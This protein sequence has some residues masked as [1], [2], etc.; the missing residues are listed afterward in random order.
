MLG[1][2]LAQTLG[3]EMP[4]HHPQLQRA[5]ASAQLNA[6]VHQV[7]DA[8]RPFARLQILGRQRKRLAHDVHAT[9]GED[10]QIE[11]REEP[12]VWIDHQRVC[13]VGA[14]ENPFV[15]GDHRG[16]A[17]ICRVD[18]Q[19]HALAF[20]QISTIAGKRIDAGARRRADRGDDRERKSS[21]PARPP[22]SRS[23]ARQARMRKSPSTGIFR[24]ES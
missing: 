10:T 13:V 15:A 19:P 17:G 8:G 14:T 1:E 7:P 18:V 11:R 23:P 22:R 24:S 4:Q 21:A 16:R 9:A 20:T 6:R 3:A 5:K 2:A 12:L